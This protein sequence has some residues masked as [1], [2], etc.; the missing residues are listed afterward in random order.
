[1]KNSDGDVHSCILLQ[2]IS[3]EEQSLHRNFIMP[4]AHYTHGQCGH[5]QIR[6]EQSDA[7][8]EIGEEFGSCQRKAT[9]TL[10]PIRK[11]LVFSLR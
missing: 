11:D 6:R 2:D 3:L 10:D 5:E 7:I 9:E 1:L 4:F 8:R